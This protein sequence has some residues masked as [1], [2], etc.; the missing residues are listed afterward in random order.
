MPPEIVAMQ[1]EA[2]TCGVHAIHN[3]IRLDGSTQLAPT[4][5]KLKGGVTFHK[6]GIT[7]P[8]VN[9]IL[10]SNNLPYVSMLTHIDPATG[11]DK[12]DQSQGK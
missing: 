4:I 5:D 8:Q 9:A 2:N 3:A 7:M 11:M 10:S 1:I 12:A 6:D